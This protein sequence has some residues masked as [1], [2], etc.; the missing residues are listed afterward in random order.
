[1]Y[2]KLQHKKCYPFNNKYFSHLIYN[3]RSAHKNIVFCVQK[4]KNNLKGYSNI[5]EKD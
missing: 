5:Y 2:K 1:M 3:S 4:K